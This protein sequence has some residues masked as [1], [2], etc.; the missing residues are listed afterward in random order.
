M[1]Q[2]WYPQGSRPRVLINW[3][4]FVNEGISAAWQDPFTDAVIN[5]YTRWM[6]VAGVDLRFQFW[7]YTSKTEADPGELVI[8]ME[9]AFGGGPVARLASTLG[10]YNRLRIAFHRRSAAD[11]TPFNFVPFNAAPGQFDMQAILMHEF[12]HCHGLD[13]SA[14]GNDTMFGGYNYFQRFGPYEGDVAAVKGL[15]AD[16][17]QNRLRQLRSG[18]GGASWTSVPNELTAY[19]HVQA[20]TTLS[21]GA[22][23]IGSGGLY[24]LGWS[25]ANRIPT[26]LRN[27]GDKFLMRR[28]FYL[29]GERSVHGPAYASDPNGTLLWAWVRNDDSGT[30]RVVRSS[31]QG[32]SWGDVGVP[33]NACSQGTPGLA[34]TSVGGQST[35]IL[36]WANF[37][38]GN[39]NTAGELR[40]SIS[41]NDGASWSAPAVL[42]SLSR[43]ASGVA[44]AATPN[45]EVMVAFAWLGLQAFGVNGIRSLRCK[46]TS[47]KLQPVGSMWPAQRT[48]IQPALA[49]SPAHNR[50]IMAWREQNFATTISTMTVAPGAST[51]GGTVMVSGTTSHVAPALASS[52][53][54]GE[55]VL[56]YAS[57]SP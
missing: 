48:R 22:G 2:Q 1:A 57:D 3:Q 6:N 20:R 37:D 33:A 28:W 42:G 52:D 14:S 56:W 9:P 26:W 8:H 39:Q 45:N 19:N 32:L 53:A 30:L 24:I 11:G 15:Y 17:S 41:T 40:A 23:H 16:Y 51:W 44:V 4:S 54:Y 7:G 27:D 29:G 55:A 49:F 21:P 5:A 36:V 50:F 46:V 10:H 35:W 31:N 38:R 25:H 18:N 34:W 13:H 12:G 47:G 43:A